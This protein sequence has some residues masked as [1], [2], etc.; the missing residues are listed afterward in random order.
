M[1]KWKQLAKI[2]LTSVMALVMVMGYGMNISAAPI[3]PPPSHNTD[4][5]A[6]IQ[7]VLQVPVGSQKP[8]ES[9]T[10]TFVREGV[11]DAD[12]TLITSSTAPGYVAP[13]AMPNLSAT[14]LATSLLP[15]TPAIVGG[16]QIFKG[17]VD[18][19]DTIDPDDFPRAGVYVYTVTETNGGT[20]NIDYSEAEYEMYVYVTNNTAMTGLEID[21]VGF[22]IVANDG[23]KITTDSLPTAVVADPTT[24]TNSTNAKAAPIFTN[25]YNPPVDLEVQKTV[26]GPF[27]DTTR[28]FIYTLVI[29]RP[30][31]T[32]NL[33]GNKTY[34]G[35]IYEGSVA[36]ADTVMVTF[37]GIATQGIVTTSNTKAGTGEF[38]LKHG[39]TL[40]FLDGLPE[41]GVREGLPAGSTYTLTEAGTAGYTASVEI[42]N[43]EATMSSST[44]TLPGTLNTTLTISQ[45]TAGG[46]RALTL[47]DAVNRTEWT[48]TYQ[49]ISPTGILI[50]NLPYILLIVVAIGGF[51]G[52]IVSKRR[53][54]IR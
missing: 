31:T 5:K 43:A 23:I 27:A 9:Y 47:G 17:N 41:A 38:L 29:N 8:T 19:L 53:Q 51:A 4:G 49:T 2:V 48:N 6:L 15:D 21:N 28:D 33:D 45:T 26:V 54:A 50:N 18:A 40:D 39:Q 3:A 22:R 7:K 44:E 46:V 12:G 14:V 11:T 20:P 32:A 30:Q 37:I 34:I 10:F 36:T 35:T 13:T 16:F 52:Y 42:W 24:G 1:K 25:K